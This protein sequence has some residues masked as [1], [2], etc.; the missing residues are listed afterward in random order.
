M[1]ALTLKSAVGM[2]ID[3]GSEFGGDGLVGGGGRL[4]RA[5]AAKD[6]SGARRDG[7]VMISTDDES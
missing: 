4:S 5:K 1:S 2:D 7:N 3:G 6:L